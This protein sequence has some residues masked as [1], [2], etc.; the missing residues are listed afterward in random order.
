M[1]AFSAKHLE[2][3]D[4]AGSKATSAHAP[5]PLL[6]AKVMPPMRGR[7]A[8]PAAHTAP[9]PQMAQVPGGSLWAQ[10]ALAELN[11]SG[12]SFEEQCAAVLALNNQILSALA[13][14][15]AQGQT[16]AASVG[17]STYSS[18][19]IRDQ[20]ASSEP[21]SSRAL[22]PP[23]MPSEGTKH[24]ANGNGMMNSDGNVDGIAGVEMSD[25][26][27]TRVEPH[28]VDGFDRFEED[29]TDIHLGDHEIAHL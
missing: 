10:S 26:I 15:Q 8:K 29:K 1:A 20:T 16:A 19:A 11:G 28:Q 2:R 22:A 27:V 7:V 17:A 9:A 24:A 5:G 3:A 21:R 4:D 13:A 25:G 6:E 14:N 23:L 12:M 18:N